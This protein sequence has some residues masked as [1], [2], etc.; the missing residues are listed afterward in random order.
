MKHIFRSTAL[1]AVVLGI[2]TSAYA[3]QPKEVS[4]SAVQSAPSKTQSMNKAVP[5]KLS[6]S[7]QSIFKQAELTVTSHNGGIYSIPTAA[8]VAQTVRILEKNLIDKNITVFAKIDHA[9]GAK[10]VGLELTDMQVIIFGDPKAGTGLMQKDATMGIELPLRLLVWA[11]TRGQTQ[12]GFYDM[13]SVVN[14]HFTEQVPNV[15]PMQE[16]IARLIVATVTQNASG[17]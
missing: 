10:Q 11:D 3:Q 4:P 15:L 12:I 1:L 9:L 5:M 13:Q 17:L 8:N 7:V 14:R 6:E 16:A 2:H